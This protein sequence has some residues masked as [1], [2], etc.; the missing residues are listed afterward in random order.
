[1]KRLFLFNIFKSKYCM[2]VF[3]LGLYLSYLIIPKAVFHGWLF[4]IGIIY[5]LLI[6]IVLTCIVRVTKEKIMNL[7][8]AGAGTSR[9]REWRSYP[10]KET[11]VGI[12]C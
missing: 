2:V 10:G 1:M 5:I 7:K 3:L 4:L 6:A 8:D 9:C 11:M 12:P